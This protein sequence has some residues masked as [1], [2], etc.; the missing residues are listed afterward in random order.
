LQEKAII[1]NTDDV[2]DV[3]SEEEKNKMITVYPDGSDYTDLISSI[4]DEISSGPWW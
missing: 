2:L 4:D 1:T 3:G